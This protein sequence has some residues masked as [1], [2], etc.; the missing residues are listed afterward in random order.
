VL[1]NAVSLDDINIEEK[2]EYGRY[3]IELPFT[4][5]NIR[6][7]FGVIEG[8][9]LMSLLQRY[10]FRTLSVPDFNQFPI[11][12]KCIGADAVK[13]EAVVL[14]SGNLALALRASMAIP[15]VFTPVEQ[16]DL[17]IVDGGLVKNFPVDKVQEMGADFVIGSYTGGTLFDRQSINNFIK[18]LY[19]SASISR[20]GEA[21]I[22]KK[23]CQ[24]LVDFD[25]VLDDI[26]AGAADFRKTKDILRVANIAVQEIMPQLENLANMQKEYAA[27]EGGAI[28]DFGFR[29]SDLASL[30][31]VKITN[32]IKKDTVKTE[33]LRGDNLKTA[34]SKADSIKADLIEIVEIN[35]ENGRETYINSHYFTE[36]RYVS[37]AEIEMEIADLYGSHNYSKIF[38]TYDKTDLNKIIKI[39]AIALPKSVFKIGL[40]HDSEIGTGITA[41]LTL[42][43]RFL[44][45]SRAFAALDISDKPKFRLDYLKRLGWSPYWLKLNSFYENVKS[46]LY[47]AGKNLDDYRRQIYSNNFSINRRLSQDANISFGFF[48]EWVKYKPRVPVNNRTFLGDNRDTLV[49]LSLYKYYATGLQFQCQYNTFESKV[50]PN[51]GSAFN[52]TARL[53]LGARRI[54][55]VIS[56]A[57][58]KLI[59]LSK[60]D[61]RPTQQYIIAVASAQMILPIAPK[62]QLTFDV[63]SGKYFNVETTP[64]NEELALLFGV[65]G[66]ETRNNNFQLIP[67]WGYREGFSLHNAFA[68]GRFG[69]QLKPI[70]RLYISP[71]LSFLYGDGYIVNTGKRAFANNLDSSWGINVGWKT[72][73]GPVQMNFSKARS[74]E[75]IRTYLS[76]GIRF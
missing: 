4:K 44:N 9:N 18:I 30:D 23:N 5:G 62:V 68:T 45:F 31:S 12:F 17:L 38:Y 50:F 39:H 15:T 37:R 55:E 66:V 40:H 53:P 60:D 76:L 70:E 64:A 36:S 33:I 74:S 13:G 19:Q 21:E 8:Q 72:P 42:R 58:D 6:L 20:I 16:G 43:D 24:I 35:P 3:P 27:T 10:T 63:A 26:K 32:E 34:I 14:D 2:D 11:P 46:T 75:N 65:G 49:Q 25:K 73:L 59:N 51:K 1:S 56:I 71:A 47:F 41:N 61:D 7:P 67:F 48:H 69:V 22:Q 29:I 28:S 57:D 54:S 52:L